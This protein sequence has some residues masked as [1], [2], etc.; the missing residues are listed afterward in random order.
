MLVILFDKY[1]FGHFVNS[2]SKKNQTCLNLYFITSG[3]VHSYSCINNIFTMNCVDFLIP[4][5]FLNPVES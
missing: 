1:I 4:T 5:G 3:H 2:T